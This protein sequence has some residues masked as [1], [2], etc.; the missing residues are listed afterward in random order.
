[1]DHFHYR[2]N[3][4]YCDDLPVADLAKTYGTPLYVYSQARDRRSIESLAAGLRRAGAAGLLLGQGE[5][6]PL[7][8]SR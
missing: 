2:D 5:L 8:S 6:E 7:A 3:Q 1:M 4:L